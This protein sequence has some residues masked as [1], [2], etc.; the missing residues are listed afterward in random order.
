MSVRNHGGPFSQRDLAAAEPQRVSP[1]IVLVEVVVEGPELPTLTK[2]VP[3]L[4]SGPL[5]VVGG[6]LKPF[7]P[8]PR[9]SLKADY[10]SKWWLLIPEGTRRWHANP[11]AAPTALKTPTVANKHWFHGHWL[12]GK[13]LKQ[14]GEEVKAQIK[15]RELKCEFYQ[16][17]R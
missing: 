14:L 2:H 8:R 13:E 10:R 1:L 15:S 9:G 4:C 6:G 17:A 12:T 16:E 5:E 3:A 11:P 7:S